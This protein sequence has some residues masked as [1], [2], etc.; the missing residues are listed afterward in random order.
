VLG[1]GRFY[2]EPPPGHLTKAANPCANTKSS[3][4][5]KFDCDKTKR[6]IA[7]W[8]KSKLGSREDE[9]RKCCELWLRVNPPGILLHH[10]AKLQRCKLA[11]KID[12]R[13]NADEL[14]VGVL[15]KDSR[16]NI[17]DEINTLDDSADGGRDLGC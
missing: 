10:L 13:T 15:L 16:K 5:S 4:S 8:Y 3:F 7:R 6:L 12:D 1:G 9:W 11:I 14:Y 17:G 2:R